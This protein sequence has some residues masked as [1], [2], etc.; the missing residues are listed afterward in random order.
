MAQFYTVSECFPKSD[1]NTKERIVNQGQY[2]P[3][4]TWMFRVRE[5]N[6]SDKWMQVNRKPDNDLKEGDQ[7]YGEIGQWPDGNPK[8]IRMQPPQGSAP[9]S[10]PRQ[11]A[12]TTAGGGASVDSKLDYIIS[13]L[14]NRANFPGN[15][16][17][18]AGGGS[19]S[20]TDIDD[21]PVDLSSLDY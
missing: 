21:G 18:Q 11:A 13:L 3:T 7:V 15:V 12:Q 1:R 16:S 9:Q 6:D 8:F 14:E 4:V 5:Y 17:A 19:E 2:G 10:A 20:I